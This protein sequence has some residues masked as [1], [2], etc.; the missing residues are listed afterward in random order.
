MELNNAELYR[1]SEK[2]SSGEREV[3]FYKRQKISPAKFSPASI[4]LAE[5]FLQQEICNVPRKPL[6]SL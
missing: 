2:N 3:I 4:V 5:I 6:G 1:L